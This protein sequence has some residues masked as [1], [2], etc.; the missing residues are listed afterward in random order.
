MRKFY[1][2]PYQGSK[3]SLAEEIIDF[4]PAGNRFVDLFGGGGSISHCASLSGKW[5]CVL[6]NEFS[7]LVAK[8]FDMAIHN[9]FSDESRWISREEFHRLKGTDPYVAICFSFNSNLLVYSYSPEVEVYAKAVYYNTVFNDSS[10][11][12]EDIKPDVNKH[13]KSGREPITRL[14]RIKSIGEEHLTNITVNCGDY[15]DYEYQ[16]GDIVYCDIPYEGTDCRFYKGFNNKEFYDWAISRPY[17][18]FFSSYD[19]SDSRF[20]I[21]WDKEKTISCGN[22]NKGGTRIE[23]IYSNFPYK[24]KN[25]FIFGK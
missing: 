16:E 18:V 25:I 1:G 24:K 10:F 12:T 9:E 22:N 7:P 5:N 8:G 11:I 21:V 14:Q 20:N 17:Q 3:N 19:I 2:L 4:L 23:R 13:T 6:Y 15:K